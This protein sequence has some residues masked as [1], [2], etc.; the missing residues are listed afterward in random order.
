MTQPKFVKDF[1]NELNEFN[2]QR[3]IMPLLGVEVVL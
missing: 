3:W 1:I 2:H